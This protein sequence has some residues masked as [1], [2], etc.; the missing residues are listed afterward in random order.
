MK[1]VVSKGYGGGSMQVTTWSTDTSSLDARNRRRLERLAN[2]YARCTD[3][4]VSTGGATSGYL[5]VNVVA[6]NWS[7]DK[8]WVEP[9]PAA[10]RN[11]ADA[12]AELARPKTVY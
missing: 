5:R 4:N 10:V 8:F 3:A 11:L 2:A 9:A 7:M 6:E 1:I 12:I